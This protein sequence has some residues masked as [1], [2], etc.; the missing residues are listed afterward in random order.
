MSSRNLFRFNVIDQ[1]G[2]SS[3][4]GPAHALKVIAAACSRGAES[5]QSVLDLADEY[6][7]EWARSVRQGLYR[8]DEHNIDTLSSGFAQV[9]SADGDQQLHPFRVLDAT[10]RQRS[11]EPA[12]LGLVVFNLKERRII[13]IQNRYAELMRN[14]RGRVRRNGLPTRQL[15]TYELSDAW[16]IVP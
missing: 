12:S 3:F 4:V 1:R 11:M 13:Q 16:S 8:F 2:V 15:F 14:D 5:L 6:D 7:A 9:G 10:T